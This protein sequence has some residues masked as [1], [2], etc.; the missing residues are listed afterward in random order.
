MELKHSILS[1][2]TTNIKAVFYQF[3]ELSVIWLVNLDVSFL[4]EHKKDAK[5]LA[6]FYINIGV[7]LFSLQNFL[8]L[9]RQQ[10]KYAFYHFDRL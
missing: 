3:M 2:K 10:I 7:Y 5:L 6:P 9:H 8:L 4:Q 1:F